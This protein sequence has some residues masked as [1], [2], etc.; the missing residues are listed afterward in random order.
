MDNQKIREE[1]VARATKVRERVAM[2]QE[3]FEW[4]VEQFYNFGWNV[5]HEVEIKK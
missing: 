3:D 5:K 2:C 1:A 4:L